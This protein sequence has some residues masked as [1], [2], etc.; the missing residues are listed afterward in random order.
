MQSEITTNISPKGLDL[1][2]P[3][4]WLD[5]IKKLIRDYKNWH[6]VQ[7]EITTNISPKGLDLVAPMSWLDS[8]KNQF[9]APYKGL[10]NGVVCYVARGHSSQSQICSFA[11]AH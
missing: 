10:R 6:I 2:A 3:M 7:S 4:S 8:I 1:V 5:P 11:E 9:P